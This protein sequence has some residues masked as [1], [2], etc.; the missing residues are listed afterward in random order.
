[1]GVDW[2]E[3]LVELY[4]CVNG[5]LQ[6]PVLPAHALL[7]LGEVVDSHA[8]MVEIW[9]DMTREM[10]EVGEATETAGDV[11]YTFL[12]S[13]IPF[14]GLDG[15]WFV[16][17]TR[18]G[19]LFGCVT[20]FDKVESDQG[21]PQ[22]QSISAMLTDLAD[23]LESTTRFGRWWRPSVVDGVLNWEFVD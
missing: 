18:P 9:G 15:Y 16:V 6:M 2:P 13:Y 4:P 10:R 19:E 14:A 5:D 21:G 11:A 22:W 8:M 7:P 12:P 17:D 20:D 23:S 1:M 3:E